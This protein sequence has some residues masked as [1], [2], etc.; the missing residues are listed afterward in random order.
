MIVFKADRVE[1]TLKKNLQFTK[2]KNLNFSF[3]FLNAFSSA[4][5]Q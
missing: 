5:M 1:I 2:I 4:I 3:I